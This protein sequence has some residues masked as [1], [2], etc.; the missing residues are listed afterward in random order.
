MYTRRPSLCHTL[1]QQRL[2]SNDANFVGNMKPVAQRGCGVPLKT[3]IERVAGSGSIRGMRMPVRDDQ[4]WMTVEGRTLLP[5][6]VWQ[7]GEFKIPVTPYSSRP[8]AAD[9]YSA[10]PSEENYKRIT[11]EGAATPSPALTAGWQHVGSG[12]EEEEEEEEEEKGQAKTGGEDDGRMRGVGGGWDDGWSTPRREHK[13][14]EREEALV[15]VWVAGDEMMDGGERLDG[16]RKTT[17]HKMRTSIIKRVD[18]YESV[19]SGYII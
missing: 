1:G 15:K 17:E 4:T 6:G 19:C 11:G 7:V 16:H 3:I 12:M 5:C 14:Y 9:T 10:K 2:A 8:T 18:P 13:A